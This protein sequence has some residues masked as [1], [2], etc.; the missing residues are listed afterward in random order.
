MGHRSTYP[1]PYT[2]SPALLGACC[3]PGL[4]VE[5][6]CESRALHRG[7]NCNCPG[8]AAG[9]RLPPS[10]CEREGFTLCFPS[11]L[12]LSPT[13]TAQWDRKGREGREPLGLSSGLCDGGGH[14]PL[15]LLADT[16]PAQMRHNS[17]GK[18]T[19]VTVLP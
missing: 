11:R 2:G 14:S 13:F 18:S 10:P 7:H 12:V 8:P 17:L 6:A 19:T 1:V 4:G 3:L 15:P 9:P 5:S 16:R